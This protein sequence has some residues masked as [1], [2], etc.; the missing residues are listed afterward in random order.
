MKLREA[1][2]FLEAL[3]EVRLPRAAY[4]QNHLFPG[5][6][7]VLSA[8]ENLADALTLPNERVHSP[9]GVA[10]EDRRC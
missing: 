7:L 9:V 5:A 10:I 4:L 1:E 3:A 8:F 2:R 6:R